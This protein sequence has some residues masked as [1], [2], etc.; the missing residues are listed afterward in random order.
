MGRRKRSGG[1]SPA[2]AASSV[3]I[4]VGVEE[5][6][7]EEGEERSRMEMETEECSMDCDK[8]S[9]DYYF[10]SYSHFGTYL[11]IYLCFIM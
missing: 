5:G 1:A 6:E 4:A 9:A 10:D 11:S 8:T 2:E 7:R 3:A